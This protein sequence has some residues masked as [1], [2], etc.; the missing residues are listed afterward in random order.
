MEKSFN[1]LLPTIHGIS[2]DQISDHIRKWRK[3]NPNDKRTDDELRPY[4]VNDL[5]TYGVGIIPKT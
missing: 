4:A 3:L 1:G 5:I 2:D